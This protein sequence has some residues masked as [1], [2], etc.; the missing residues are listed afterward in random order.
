MALAV[1]PKAYSG[2]ALDT[3][4]WIWKEKKKIIYTKTMQRKKRNFTFSII[5]IPLKMAWINR[6]LG[7]EWTCT[8]AIFF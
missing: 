5:D 4:D 3:F 1:V 8:I 6:D 2:P 7:P